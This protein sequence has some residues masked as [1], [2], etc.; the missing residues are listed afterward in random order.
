[1]AA[2]Q[3]GQI[4]LLTWSILNDAP[5]SDLPPVGPEAAAVGVS[6]FRL[7]TAFVDDFW[8]NGTT[9]PREQKIGLTLLILAVGLGAAF[10][11]R[12]PAPEEAALPG[13]AEEDRINDQVAELKT[14]PLLP[15]ID[16]DDPSQLVAPATP[17]QLA[18]EIAELRPLRSPANS[19]F[20][21]PPPIGVVADAPPR[22]Q[23]REVPPPREPVASTPVQTTTGRNQPR[24][25][26]GL[27]HE[28]LPGET[29][30]GIALKYYGA[31]S[32]YEEIFKANR[33]ILAS[34]NHL[35][36]GMKLTIP[37]ASLDLDT[38]QEIKE[39][40][41]EAEPAVSVISPESAVPAPIQPTAGEEPD[42]SAST[43]AERRKRMF[44]PA[45]HTPFGGMDVAPP[46]R[47][48]ERPQQRY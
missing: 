46:V 21:T 39:A 17:D 6:R 7:G 10:C 37:Q 40:R 48:A 34:P 9:M 43:L 28:V 41:G 11:F 24:P 3:R 44:V 33:D 13:L 22:S 2:G 4:L 27:T 12:R 36:P 35:R 45:R 23:Q 25:A 26:G 15:G 30:T 38:Q 8:G 5:P 14:R 42:D 31:V 29:L 47:S 18:R 16:L 32:R 19:G 1:L 20:R